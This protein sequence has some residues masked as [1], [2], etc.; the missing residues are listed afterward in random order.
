MAYFKYLGVTAAESYLSELTVRFCQPNNYNDPFELLPEIRLI[1]E[2]KD[3]TSIS[4][5]I[6]GGKSEIHKYEILEENITNYKYILNTNLI[7]QI[8]SNIG[9]TCFSQSNAEIPVNILMWAH[10][11]ESHRGIAIQLKSGCEIERQLVQIAYRKNRPVIDGDKLLGTG[12]FPLRDLYVK[13]THWQYESEFRVARKLEECRDLGNEIFVSEIHPSNIERIVLG[14][15]SSRNLKNLALR[16]HEEFG[17]TIILT[18]RSSTGFGFKPYAVF[19]QS[20]SAYSEAII[21]FEKYTHE[22]SR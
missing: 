1:N 4:I 2:C 3:S 22:S 19:A 16:F 9:T 6:S 18:H 8:S 17:T 20:N 13:S 11:A 10:Y 12:N 7:E 5:D 14:I 15:N 21:L